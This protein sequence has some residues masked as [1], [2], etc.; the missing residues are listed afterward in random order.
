MR[1]YFRGSV[2]FLPAAAK[3]P[4][5]RAH[6]GNV[7]ING[8]EFVAI[9]CPIVDASSAPAWCARSIKPASTNMPTMSIGH[10]KLVVEEDARA[11]AYISRQLC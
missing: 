10:T 1:F 4:R 11:M 7:E 3:L 6:C 9:I 5:V 2:S 8:Q